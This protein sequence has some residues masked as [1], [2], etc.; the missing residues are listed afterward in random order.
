M[1]R[2][3]RTQRWLLRLLLGLFLLLVVEVV[4]VGAVLVSPGARDAVS[5]TV[6]RA[7]DAV[8][9]NEE[10]ASL[11]ARANDRLQ[12]AYAGWIEPL[13]ATPTMSETVDTFGGCVSCHED[14]ATARRFGDLY[15]DHPVHAELGVR[16]ATCHV[17]VT[18]P[19]PPAPE[20]GVCVDC[21]AEDVQ[22]GGDCALCHAPGALPHF[23]LLGAPRDGMV[24]CETCHTPGS[25]EGAT[26]R[27]HVVVGAFDGSSSEDC[28]SCHKPATCESCH[29]PGHPPDWLTAHGGAADD[30]GTAAC[31]DCHTGSWCADSCHAV[32][33][34]SPFEPRPLP[35]GAP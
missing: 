2:R 9:G 12:G 21:H 28:A 24:A 16:C 8:H 35:E 20:E 3:A 10:L 4:V 19:S 33:P 23:L 32:T 25:L 27:E 34:T 26:A 29:E 5:I 22:T 15:M 6:A 11:P 1:T 31:I 18:H 13:Y 14:I 7:L 17:E 30:A